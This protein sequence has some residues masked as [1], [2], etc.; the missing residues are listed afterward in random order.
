MDIHLDKA[1]DHVL[2]RPTKPDV[3]DIIW[4]D[5]VWTSFGIMSEPRPNGNSRGMDIQ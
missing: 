4:S 3:Q 5:V 1:D 2:Q